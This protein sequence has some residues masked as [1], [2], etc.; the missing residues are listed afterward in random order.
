MIIS[1]LTSHISR[2]L[3]M[4]LAI[5]LG[6]LILHLSQSAADVLTTFIRISLFFQIGLIGQAA[7]NLLLRHTPN[8]LQENTPDTIMMGFSLLGRIILWAVIMLL[9]LENIGINITTLIASLG[10]GGIAIGLAL[11]R[12]MGDLISSLAIVLDKPFIPGDYIALDTF[13]GTVER[14]GL[15]TTRIRS[16]TGEE[17][18]IS[19]ADLI[20][21][22]IQ[23][24]RTMM[25]RRIVMGFGVTYDTTADTLEKIPKMVKTII[26][27]FP[28]VRFDRAHFKTL[29]ASS[30]DF[31]VVYYMLTP[32]YV[33]FMDVQQAI[34]LTLIRQFAKEQIEFAFPSQTLYIP[35]LETVT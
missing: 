16:L 9:S 30:L 29:A 25:E 2:L 3:L 32:N 18:V 6:S 23:N 24:Y 17:L 15:K 10:V 12:V 13:S 26:A 5:Y 20:Q 22:R 8:K 11:Q 4:A 21:G 31:E 34:N 28:N 35:A 7:I 1:I 33:E 19:N 27:S 14:I